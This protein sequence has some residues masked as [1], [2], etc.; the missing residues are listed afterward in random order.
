L[1]LAYNSF[2]VD[3]PLNDKSKLVAPSGANP[4]ATRNHFDVLI[5][6]NF[7][8]I[9]ASET[10]K[11]GSYPTFEAAI[12]VSKDIVEQDLRAA[13]KPGMTPAELYGSYV[14]FGEDPYL[15]GPGVDR[16][17]F[18]AWIY[19]KRRCEEICAPQ[20]PEPT[21]QAEISL[22]LKRKPIWK[23]ILSLFPSSKRQA[24]SRRA[25]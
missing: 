25:K 4:A 16:V 20:T 13:Y 6:D 22:Q 23:T 3:E 11:L 21:K 7:H 5:A 19:A 24:S 8:Y 15:V 17:S 18:S 12:A 10:Y 1:L 9:D 14:M 2:G